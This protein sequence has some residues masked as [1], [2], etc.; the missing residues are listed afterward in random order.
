MESVSALSGDGLGRKGCVKSVA[1]GKSFDDHTEGHNVIGAASCVGVAEIDLVLTGTLLMMRAFGR[2]AHF[3]KCQADLTADV[4]AL[5]SGRDVHIS[6]LIEGD[7]GRLALFVGTEEIELTFRADVA[8][9]THRTCAFGRLSE[10]VTSVAL[11]GSAVGIADITEEADNASLRGSPG[12]ESKGRGIGE[13]EEVASLSEAADR[14]RVKG[15][16]HLKGARKLIGH[17]RDILLRPVNVAERQTYELYVIFLDEFYYFLFGVSHGEPL[18]RFMV[19]T[20]YI[21]YSGMS[22]FDI[23]L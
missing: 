2:D 18:C 1:G 14:R 17:Y 4:F 6:A 13:K 19:Y 21:K 23:T 10:D 12:Q 22:R 16:A 11:E 3:L 9:N 8:G 7:I 15:Y 5:I 20:F